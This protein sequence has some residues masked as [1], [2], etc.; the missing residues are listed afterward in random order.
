LFFNV[1]RANLILL[2]SIL[3]KFYWS[4]GDDTSASSMLAARHVPLIMAE[5][6]EAGPLPTLSIHIASS[7]SLIL[8]HMVFFYLCI[9]PTPPRCS[10]HTPMSFLSCSPSTSFLCQPSASAIPLSYDVA[11]RYFPTFLPPIS[12]ATSSTMLLVVVTNAASGGGGATS[13]SRGASVEGRR[14]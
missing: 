7:R 14:C 12:P 13:W 11:F 2:T 5:G 8:S 4:I 3:G 10:L 6:K 1:N 9:S